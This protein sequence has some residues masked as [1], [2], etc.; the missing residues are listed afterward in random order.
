[1][2]IW[3]TTVSHSSES[4][5]SCWR[6]FNSIAPSSF[7]RVFQTTV[8]PH[9][10]L[11]QVLSSHSI[12][13]SSRTVR[14]CTQWRG[15]WIGY[16]RTTWSNMIGLFFCATL[17]SCRGGARVGDEN[18]V[19][20]RIVHPRCPVSAGW[21][22]LRSTYSVESPPTA[23]GGMGRWLVWQLVRHKRRWVPRRF[24]KWTRSRDIGR[25]LLG[26]PS[27]LSGLGIATIGA[28]V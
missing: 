18:V 21:P 5:Q 24:S 15:R 27:V 13:S 25:Y 22:G 10:I 20:Y 12:V 11:G 1:M 28:L 14:P 3:N 6:G 19:S 2:N 26:S 23:M 4:H 8:W 17:I 16:W 7:A 9:E